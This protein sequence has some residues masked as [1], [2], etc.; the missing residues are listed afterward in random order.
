MLPLHTS[1]SSL[2]GFLLVA[3]STTPPA[4]DPR[5]TEQV[6]T[7][8][9]GGRISVN[10]NVR[11]GLGDAIWPIGIRCQRD[12]G[13]L[14]DDKPTTVQFFDRRGFDGPRS[15]SLPSRVVCRLG[16]QAIWGADLRVLEAKYLVATTI[17][18]GVNYY[19]NVA[20]KFVGK[21]TLLAESAKLTADQMRQM[22]ECDA[23]RDAYTKRVRTS[24]APGMKVAFGMII[25][26]RGSIA[27]IQYDSVGRQVKR[28]DQEWVQV[29]SLLAGDECPR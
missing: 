18:T 16:E 13:T 23:L 11:Q 25:E 5:T 6:V 17:G 24:P 21:E 1:I 29:S 28:T 2:L 3:C 4:A 12:G 27:L 10:E 7:Q 22:R 8:T 20:T 9:S 15:V 26:V 19:G 14:T